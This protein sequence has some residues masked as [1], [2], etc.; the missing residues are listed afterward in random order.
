MRRKKRGHCDPVMANR[1]QFKNEP[2]TTEDAP[3]FTRQ[4]ATPKQSAENFNTSI[5]TF[6]S[7]YHKGMFPAKVA[8]GRIFRFDLDVVEKALAEHSRKGGAR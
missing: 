8:V 7:W 4:S 1:T 5:P 6:L 2:L 3:A